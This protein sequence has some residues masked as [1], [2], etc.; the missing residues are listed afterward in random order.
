MKDILG[1]A[2]ASSWMDMVETLFVIMGGVF[3]Y[4]QW[5]R[6]QRSRC[7]DLYGQL[8]SI[9]TSDEIFHAFEELID[10]DG[11]SDVEVEKNRSE[12]SQDKQ[13]VRLDKVLMFLN[14]VCYLYGNK[15]IGEKEFQ[16][17]RYPMLRTLSNKKVLKYIEGLKSEFA[18]DFM[19]DSLMAYAEKI[20]IREQK[21]A[22]CELNEAKWR[23]Y[24]IMRYGGWTHTAESVAARVNAVCKKMSVSLD[25]LVSTEKVARENLD[26]IESLFADK[27]VAQISSFRTAVR[28][29]CMAKHGVWLN[30]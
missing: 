12:I 26:A 10:R 15:M 6:D 19:Y 24:L 14:Q 7:A 4:Y 21:K 23:E 2:F 27:S 30:N 3:A 1:M 29:C 11:L 22:C 5:R 13:I 28:H 9:F 20:E 16:S 17:F 18:N 8:V 25:G